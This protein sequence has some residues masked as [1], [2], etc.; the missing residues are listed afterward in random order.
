MQKHLALLKFITY[1]YKKI[2]LQIRYANHTRI[3]YEHLA[4]T[5]EQNVPPIQLRIY[6]TVI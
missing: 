4:K 5:L 1:K 2:N 3:C 6:Y